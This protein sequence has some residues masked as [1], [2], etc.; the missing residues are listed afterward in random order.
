MAIIKDNLDDYVVA[1][2]PLKEW[3]QSDGENV[4]Y[5]KLGFHNDISTDPQIVV[6]DY[7]A[8]VIDTEAFPRA[9]HKGIDLSRLAGT[10]YR[11]EP[12]DNQRTIT[13]YDGD[14]IID[15]LFNSL[16]NPTVKDLVFRE[17]KLV[18][19]DVYISAETKH[20][21]IT[22]K[23]NPKEVI[24]AYAEDYNSRIIRRE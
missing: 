20:V 24:L 21:M 15:M 22:I 3:Y 18:A 23:I 17:Y 14:D 8:F 11:D 6:V 10:L 13:C 12:Y 4:D 2:K 5:S 16:R 1:G 7:G 9:Y 19:E